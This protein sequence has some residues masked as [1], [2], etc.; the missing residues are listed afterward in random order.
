MNFQQVFADTL[1]ALTEMEKSS[2]AEISALYSDLTD[3]N[4]PAGVFDSARRCVAS[5]VLLPF[6][7]YSAINE[8]K[9]RNQLAKISYSHNFEGDWKLVDELVRQDPYTPAKVLEYYLSQVGPHSYFG[10][11]LP[12]MK[13]IKRNMQPKYLYQKSTAPVRYPERKRG[14]NDKGHLPAR[15]ISIKG[16]VQKESV[17]QPFV[18]IEIQGTF[19]SNTPLAGNN[20]IA[21]GLLEKPTPRR[22]RARRKKQKTASTT[23]TRRYNDG[24]KVTKEEWHAIFYC[25]KEK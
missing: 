24:I 2:K 7:G 10:N 17:K 9:L 19:Y 4:F 11:T 25:N 21:A 23:P 18:E 6:L 1:G 8:T 20:N 12:L 3:W 14:Y 5:A 13:I 16:K 22:K 15:H